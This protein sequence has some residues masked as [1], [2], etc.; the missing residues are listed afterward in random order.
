MNYEEE[1]DIVE[2]KP[3]I[4][5][6]KFQENDITQQNEI[7]DIEKQKDTPLLSSISIKTEI[8]DYD[9]LLQAPSTS[10][11]GNIQIK[12]EIIEEESDPFK[13]I[14]IYYDFNEHTKVD[15]ESEEPN[16]VD[17]DKLLNPEQ[18]QT[19]SES[20]PKSPVASASE[21][22]EKQFTRKVYFPSKE[23][24]RYGANISAN[25]NNFWSQAI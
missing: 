17:Y 21:V 12:S 3:D 23:S 20:P 2:W 4:S 5:D 22:Q 6:F 9:Q 13:D 11:S 14:D 1:I 18:I 8:P 10:A 24:F 7:N 15:I 16:F 25:N 19:E